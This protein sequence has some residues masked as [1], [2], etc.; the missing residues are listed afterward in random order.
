MAFGVHFIW[1]EVP[2]FE[3]FPRGLEDWFVGWIASSFWQAA[4]G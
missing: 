4:S 1:L 3:P 2:S